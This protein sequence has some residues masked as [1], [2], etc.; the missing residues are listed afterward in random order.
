MDEP[1]F[2]VE[3]PDPKREAQACDR[4]SGTA[5]ASDDRLRV[6]GWLVYDGVSETGKDLH[7]RISPYWAPRSTTSTGPMTVTCP[8]AG[9]ADY[10]P[11]SPT[12][13]CQR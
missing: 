11:F 12:H 1:L 13:P 9:P 6:L 2:D 5:W 7:V 3:N 8:A 4:C 10:R